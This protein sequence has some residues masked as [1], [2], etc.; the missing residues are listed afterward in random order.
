MKRY[1][2]DFIKRDLSEKIILITGPRQVGKTTISKMIEDEDEYEYLNYDYPEHRLIIHR[3]SWNRDKKIIIFDEIHK[4][5]GWKNFLKG[6]YDVEGEQNKIIVTGSARLG[7]KRKQGDS[8]AGR[9]F[10]YRLFPFDLSEVFDKF[11]I[12]DAF[13]RLIN[14]SGFPEPF[15]KNNKTFYRRWKRTH[16]DIIIKQDL[17]ETES[18]RSIS[19]I[20][21]LIEL[22]RERIGSPISYSGL[23][24]DLQRDVK[25][26]KRWLEILENL[27][28]V[29]KITPFHRN[30]SRSLLKMPKYYFFDIALI[31]NDLS[32]KIE[33]LV[34]LSLKKYLSFL[35]DTKGYETMLSYLRNKDSRE[36]DFYVRIEDNDY[37]I[38]VKTS[39]TKP[40]KNFN[41]FKKYFPH[42]KLI[43]LVLNINNEQIYQNGVKV[44]NLKRWL[45][46]INS[47]LI[48]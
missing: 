4:M 40:S 14:F 11:E 12:N 1:I 22:L 36:I 16:N 35:E 42:A 34:A 46:N 44:N 48:E 7:F 5:K 39:D 45:S 25:T 31:K 28:L 17:L 2:E 23:A 20:E 29:F 30:I 3:M 47:E 19:S 21:L 41:V 6:I 38:E 8:L 24:L 13:E 9:F 27:Y 18:V 37:L 15:L 33:N 10:E 26:V 43:Q 32:V